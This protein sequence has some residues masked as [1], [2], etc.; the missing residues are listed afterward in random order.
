MGPIF[1]K[2]KGRIWSYRALVKAIL[3]RILR[4]IISAWSQG[5]GFSGGVV[6]GGFLCFVS[7]PTIREQNRVHFSKTILT[8]GQ[9]FLHDF[10]R[11]HNF[12]KN[13]LNFSKTKSPLTIGK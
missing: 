6:Q 13:S 3:N 2:K 5:S 12:A 11:C 4:S 1:G 7:V 9:L 8:I 10:K